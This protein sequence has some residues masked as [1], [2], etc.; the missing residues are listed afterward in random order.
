M[1]SSSLLSKSGISWY[2]RK[3]RL[4]LVVVFCVTQG[5]IKLKKTM[6]EDEEDGTISNKKPRMASMAKAKLYGCFVKV[7]YMFHF[8][9]LYQ[10]QTVKYMIKVKLLMVEND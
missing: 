9:Y 1:S 10:S 7:I 2:S 3:Q 8:S 5:D 6:E 4:K